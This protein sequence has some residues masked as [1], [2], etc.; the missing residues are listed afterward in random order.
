MR[1]YYIVF[2]IIFFVGCA[3]H[4][5]VEKRVDGIS[6]ISQNPK[7]YTQNF[8]KGYIATLESYK[9]EY[10]REWHTSKPYI[11][12][13]KAMW[14]HRVFQYPK[15]YGENFQKVAQK[16]YEDM[17]EE[18]NFQEFATLNK[19]AITLHR[20]NVRAFP[21]NKALFLNPYKAGEG[22]PFDY[23]QNSSLAA[24]KPVLVS[25]YSKDKGWIFIESSFVYGWVRS[26]AIAFI[27]EQHATQWQKAQQMVIVKDKHAVYDNTE[28][29]LFYSQLGQLLPKTPYFHIDDDVYNIGILPFN[30][31]NINKILQELQKNIY[32]WGGMY[33]ERDCSATIRDFFAP[34]GIWL[35]R[36]SSKQSQ[37]GKVISLDGMDDTQKLQTIKKYG[38]A[39][40][41]LLYKKGHILLYV[42]T[43]HDKVIVF[44]NTWGLKTSQWGKDGR[45]IIGKAIF[46]TL[47]FGKNVDGY[48]SQNSIL[49]HLKSMNIVTQ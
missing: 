14:P 25:H 18:A 7:V 28:R 11:T 38:I 34:F 43:Y 44:H 13:E 12:K 30:G 32:G 6:D 49:H 4:I 37:I 47:D 19:K 5:P 42:G 27:D 8:D 45:Y 31:S 24:F 21:T 46:S 23:L 41:T 48:E 40:E 1:F 36:N 33:G 29:F 9:K 20:V 15:Y 22:F 35:P 10:Y 3:T 26:D 16:F 2:Y 17:N 39:F